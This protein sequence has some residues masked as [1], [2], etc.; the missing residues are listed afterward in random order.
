MKKSYH[1]L[2]WFILLGFIFSSF[3]HSADPEKLIVGKWKFEEISS[4]DSAPNNFVTEISKL[5]TGMIVEYKTDSSM[6]LEL[7]EEQAKTGTFISTTP[8]YYRYYLLQENE[9]HYL[10]HLQNRA[11]TK[12]ELITLNSETLSF[13]EEKT[14]SIFSRFKQ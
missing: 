12:Y 11:E 10:V 2:P 8:N 1:I 3:T 5:F 13:K 4:T 9:K 14:T 6:T 7:S